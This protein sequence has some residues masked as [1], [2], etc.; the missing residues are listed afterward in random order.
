[1]WTYLLSSAAAYL[2]GAIPCSYLVGKARGID[3]RQ[4]GSGNVGA[5]NVFRVVGK[6]WGILAFV[7]D[8]A[9]GF[10]PAFVFPL[11]AARSGAAVEPGLLAVACGCSAVVGHV[12]PV[13]LGFKGGKGIATSAGVL[14]GIAPAAVG[15]GVLV[16]G[17]VFLLTR[18][19]SLASILAAAVIAVGAWFL[20]WERGVPASTLRPAALSA[21]SLLTIYRHKSNI[22]R[23]L[24]G[25]EHRFTRKKSE[26]QLP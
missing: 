22:Q 1:M 21:L 11:L 7:G 18:Y 20:Y 17:A 13:F 4:H 8:F 15:I 6:P 16:F 26:A 5:T 2:I 25:T 19:V 9:K 3:I 24:N 14:L 12:F 10:V 23:L